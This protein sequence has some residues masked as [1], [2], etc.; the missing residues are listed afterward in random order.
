[1]I[2][3]AVEVARRAHTG[4]L[5]KGLP[6]PYIVHPMRVAL[7]AVEVGMGTHAICAAL[8]HDVVEDTTVTQADLRVAGFSLR[9]LELVHILTKTYGDDAPEDVKAV[10]KPKYYARIMSDPDAI[11]LKVL[12]RIDNMRDMRRMLEGL[13]LTLTRDRGRKRW[14]QRYLE[15]T[16]DEFQPLIYASTLTPQCRVWFYQELL[17]LVNLCATPCS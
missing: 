4:Q 10:E 15:K 6:D 13:D 1:M 9:T 17:E 2:D 16:R 12:D 14:A 7:L 11:T 5:R 3:Q 8:L